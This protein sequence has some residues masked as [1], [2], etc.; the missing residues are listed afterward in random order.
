MQIDNAMS[1]EGIPIAILK[2]VVLSGQSQLAV[3]VSSNL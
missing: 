1:L 2:E 3:A